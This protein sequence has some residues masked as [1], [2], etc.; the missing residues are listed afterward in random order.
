MPGRRV[1]IH[2][3]ATDGIDDR[4]TASDLTSQLAGIGAQLVVEVL[5]GGLDTAVP[6]TA[7]GVSYAAKITTEDRRLDWSRPAVEL[8]RTVRIGGAWTTF[9]GERLKVL[10]Q[11]LPA[12]RSGRRAT[13]PRS[14]AP[15]ARGPPSTAVLG[16]HCDSS[17][18]SP[19][20]VLRWTL[21]RGPGVPTPWQ[22]ASAMTGSIPLGDDGVRTRRLALAA[23]A[24]IDDDGA[25][26]KVTQG[27]RITVVAEE[28][29]PTRATEEAVQAL[30]AAVDEHAG[31]MCDAVRFIADNG[32]AAAF[33]AYVEG[34][35]G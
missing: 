11:L 22:N 20:V 30:Q 33:I 21:Q 9:R 27:A 2:P 35:N 8:A 10:W 31:T 18:C 19:P 14:A 28:D 34:E 25:Y 29:W 5:D 17:R 15:S 16:R 13:T 1:R 3:H 7:E 32:L 12:R 26:V 4:V 24:R 23:L 6:Q